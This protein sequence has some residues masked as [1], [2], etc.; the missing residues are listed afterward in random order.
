MKTVKLWRS[1]LRALKQLH[2]SVRT[3]RR[4]CLETGEAEAIHRFRV[5]LR[6]L[7]T[8]TRLGREALG[9]GNVA[10]FRAWGERVSDASGTTRD[11]DITLAW[12]KR[13]P[14][15]AGLLQTLASERAQLWETARRRLAGFRRFASA[16]LQVRYAGRKAQKALLKRY[17][18]LFGEARQQVHDFNASL[19]TGSP[20][21]AHDLRRGLRR[22]RYLYELQVDKAGLKKDLFLK[23]LNAVQDTL[24]EAQNLAATMEILF[25]PR[26]KSL[27]KS[28]LLRATLEQERRQWLRKAGQAL[29]ALKRSRAWKEM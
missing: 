25:R 19:R 24:G 6:R 26:A 2:Q 28:A 21:A 3:E 5:R 1:W 17:A 7:R 4:A 29:A 23:R 22:L 18:K 14:E 10:T 13:R 16:G 11:H 15:Y 8:Y 12:L 9:E 27:P 20:E